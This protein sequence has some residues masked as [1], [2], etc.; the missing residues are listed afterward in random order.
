MLPCL[1][2]FTNFPKLLSD[3]VADPKKRADIVLIS[4][5]AIGSVTPARVA[6][7]GAQLKAIQIEPHACC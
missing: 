6:N 2:L 7:L 3:A 4:R 1:P 5:P